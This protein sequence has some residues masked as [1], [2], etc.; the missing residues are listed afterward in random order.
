[1][2]SKK[3]AATPP[4]RDSRLTHLLATALGDDNALI[5]CLVYVPTRRATHAEAMAALSWA[6]KATAARLKKGVYAAASSKAM[7]TQLQVCHGNP[8]RPLPSSLLPRVLPCPPHHAPRLPL[9]FS[10][11]TPCMCALHRCPPPPHP[12]CRGRAWSPRSRSPTTR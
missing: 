10:H 11:H 5:H 4:L 7:V 9:P 3:K 8:S 2:G 6:S 12:V 1:M